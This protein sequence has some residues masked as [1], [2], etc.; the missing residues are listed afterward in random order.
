MMTLKSLGFIGVAGIAI[1]LSSGCA[2]FRM[3]T[4]SVDPSDGRHY[5]QNYDQTDLKELST[6]ITA[7]LLGS[8]FMVN[9]PKPPI[10]MIAPLANNTDEHID[11]KSLTDKMRVTLLQSGQVRFIN[12]TR[13]KAIMDE[14]GFQAA[15]VTPGQNVAIGQQLGVKYML[16]G[17][18][19]KIEKKSG[20]QVR[21]SKK[22]FSYYKLTM[23]VTDVETAELVWI[24]EHEIARESSK[25]LIGW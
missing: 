1:S 22:Y 11:T 25:P 24:A 9:Q 17:S 14:Q 12:E 2:A 5:N 23:E 15:N 20:K 7:Q 8:P 16:S 19:S 18:F 4:N 3:S 6:K 21:V 10:M 13:R